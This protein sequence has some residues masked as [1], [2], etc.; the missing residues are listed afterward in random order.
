MVTF[1]KKESHQRNSGYEKFPKIRFSLTEGPK[2]VAFGSS[3]SRACRA[4]VKSA[5]F[6][7]NF[8]DAREKQSCSFHTT[9]NIQNFAHA[10][11]QSCNHA[12]FGLCSLFLTLSS[13]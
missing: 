5:F 3:N 12:F 11:T 9:F 8:P 4:F 6:D 2:L 1:F 10:A 13:C 7:G